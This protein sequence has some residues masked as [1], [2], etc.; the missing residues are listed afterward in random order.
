MLFA[1]REDAG[2]QLAQLLMP[3]RE[4]APLVL[5]LP[6][7][8]VSVAY[9][10]AR[11]LGAPLDVWV[12]R[13][14]GAPHFP[15]LGIGAV[16]EGGVVY[17][18]RHNVEQVGV[19]QE[20]VQEMVRHKS[21]EVA[22]RVKLLRGDRSLPK[23]AGR[24]IILVDDGIATGGTVRAAVQALRA[25]HAGKIVLAVPVAASQSLA[26]L[27][28]L[29]EEVVCLKSTPHLYAIGAWYE[30]FQQVPDHEV[31]RLLE[32]AAHQGF[33]PLPSSFQV[34]P[35]EPKNLTISL[36][37]AEV[38]G[39]LISPPSPQ[40][41]VLFAHGSGSSRFS[42]RNRHVASVL[43]RYGLATLLFDLLTGREEEIDAQTGALRFDIDLLASRLVQVT[44][45]V[46]D[47][48]Q[49]GTLPLGY[50]GASTGAAAALVAAARRP[51]VIRAVVSRG[52]R[53]DLAGDS[54]ASVRACTLLLVGGEDHEVLRLNKQAYGHMTAPRK[55][56]VIPRATHLFEEPGTLD[57]VAR[58]AGE[59]FCDHLRRSKEMMS[60]TDSANRR[61]SPVHP[62][63]GA[64]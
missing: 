9:E 35:L 44:D 62:T 40:G 38:K 41:L 8:G 17:L 20:D 1:D 34:D 50:F 42:P 31:I 21:A 52:G 16:A 61:A 46:T 26:E 5:G 7:G 39:T 53:P 28:P 56:V 25:A 33:G 3:W 12:V 58:L 49:I 43:H 23:L 30:N 13:K 15:E 55:L 63:I 27:E 51:K 2:C 22:E 19:S 48:A 57:A 4:E 54:L 24:N 14:I 60:I 36:K 59:W 11:A 47:F 18:D 37:R 32:M 10:V 45:W 64:P 29:V 6:R